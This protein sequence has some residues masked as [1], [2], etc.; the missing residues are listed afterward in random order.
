MNAP[1]VL[2]IGRL[3][4]H[5]VAPEPVVARLAA[6]ALATEV[7]ATLPSLPPQAVLLL[8]RLELAV[9]GYGLERLPDV[10]LRQRFATAARAAIAAAAAT[11]GRPAR[12]RIAADTTAVLFGDEAELLACLA[13]DGLADRLN[14]W[15]WRSLLGNSYPDWTRA[16]VE[17]PHAATAALRLLARVGLAQAAV[18]ALV[19]R[20]MPV[21]GMTQA[22]SLGGGQGEP[23]RS[24]ASGAAAD[25]FTAIPAATRTPDAVTVDTE[26]SI[27][28]SPTAPVSP[29]LDETDENRGIQPAAGPVPEPR[30][31]TPAGTIRTETPLLIQ[32]NLTETREPGPSGATRLDRRPPS[33]PGSPDAAVEAVRLTVIETDG[34]IPTRPATPVEK[35]PIGPDV[36]AP[37]ELPQDNRFPAEPDY[38]HPVR[39]D[40]RTDP[41]R[42]TAAPEPSGL[43]AE[44][45]RRFTRIARRAARRRQAGAS[46]ATATEPAVEHDYPASSDRRLETIAPGADV[47]PLVVTPWVVVSRYARLFFLVNLLLGDGLYPDFTRPL[48]PGFPVPLWRLLA[49]LGAGLAGPVLCED[50][51]WR[52]LEQLGEELPT[53]DESEFERYWPIPEDEAENG[54]RFDGSRTRT[55]GFNGWFARYLASVRARLASA[56]EVSPAQVGGALVGEPA[57]IWVSAAEIV[58]VYRL[59]HHPVEWRLAGLDRDPGYLPSVGRSLRFIFE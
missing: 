57:R 34:A 24:P 7:A 19:A 28:V 40:H 20:G 55:A 26:Q 39:P 56:L 32:P 17:R 23:P 6:E 5:T 49:L 1:P 44:V 53:R 2:A 50:A 36:Q 47:A 14:T 30:E 3:R 13:R 42:L 43:P 22:W 15:W 37:F 45:E 8:R 29:V 35:T 46:T 10:H 38:P 59:E 48:D 51:I 25:V 21:G 41:E 12:D 16:W 33:L 31:P 9:P 58:V 18:Q 54:Q 27:V 4:A 11:A 52:L